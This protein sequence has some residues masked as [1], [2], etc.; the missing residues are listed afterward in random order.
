MHTD[1]QQAKIR[2]NVEEATQNVTD[3]KKTFREIKKELD[4]LEREEGLNH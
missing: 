2:S 3:A 4:E 1:E